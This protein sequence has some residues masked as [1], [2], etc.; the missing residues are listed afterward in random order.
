MHP[1]AKELAFKR[2]KQELCEYIDNG[3]ACDGSQLDPVCLIFGSC[4]CV[5]VWSCTILSGWSRL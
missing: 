2:R 4:V 5:L 3:D 1:S